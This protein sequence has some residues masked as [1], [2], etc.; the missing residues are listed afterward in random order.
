MYWICFV[1]LP[2]S[3]TFPRW[4]KRICCTLNHLPR[5]I[6]SFLRLCGTLQC[7]LPIVETWQE[8]NIYPPSVLRE[9]L[10]QH[11]GLPIVFQGYHQV[12]LFSLQFV[13]YVTICQDSSCPLCDFVEHYN[14]LPVVKTWQEADYYPPIVLREYPTQH[15]Y[16]QIFFQYYH[17]VYLV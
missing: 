11:Q 10:R 4:A 13:D 2:S 8:A 15:Q 1:A 5:F 9:H 3:T 6:L 7:L 14:V 16:I 17:Q 12:F